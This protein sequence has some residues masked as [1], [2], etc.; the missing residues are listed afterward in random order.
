MRRAARRRRLSL[1]P[2]IDVIFLLLL[3]FMLS[4]TFTRFAEVD[5]AAAGTARPAPPETR[6]VFLQLE[7]EAVRLNGRDL[8]LEALPGAIEPGSAEA[9][10]P[11]LVALRGAVTA[12]RLTDLLVVLRGVTGIEV[13]VLGA[14]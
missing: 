9:A 3:F 10:Q 13:T 11:V 6:P 7:P 8:A 5:L 2:L 4:S 14:P 1:T 12:Q